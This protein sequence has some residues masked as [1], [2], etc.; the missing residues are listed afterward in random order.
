MI[1]CL[2]HD[3][4]KKLVLH[5]LLLMVLMKELG[6]ILQMD[7]LIILMKANLLVTC[8]EDDLEIK[9]ILH[10]ILRMVMMN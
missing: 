4:E 7:R 2:D 8:L 9:L 5:L 1:P 10:L 6:W 3:L